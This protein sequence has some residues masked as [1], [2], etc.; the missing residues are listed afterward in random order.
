M[1]TWTTLIDEDLSLFVLNQTNDDFN[2]RKHL[3][4]PPTAINSSG[5]D[6]A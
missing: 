4:R 6:S 1:S 5:R 2:A 3:V